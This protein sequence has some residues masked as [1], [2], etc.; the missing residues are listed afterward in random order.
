MEHAERVSIKD[1]LLNYSILGTLVIT[2]AC[3]VVILS[4][5][6]GMGALYLSI[7]AILGF[8]A[9]FFDI[10]AISK[11]NVNIAGVAMFQYPLGD[12][13]YMHGVF[14]VGYIVDLLLTVVLGYEAKLAPN[15]FAPVFK[16]FTF[17]ITITFASCFHVAINKAWLTARIDLFTEEKSGRV[18]A[19]DEE[20]ED[21]SIMMPLPIHKKYTLW[22]PAQQRFERFTII[23]IIIYI[24]LLMLNIIDI[25]SQL[26]VNV[27]I[28][29]LPGIGMEGPATGYI[30]L[31]QVIT[32]ALSTIFFVVVLRTLYI[33]IYDYNIEHLSS[34]LVKLEP[35]DIKRERII[36]FLEKIKD[37]RKA[38]EL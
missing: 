7:P 30:S 10:L 26:Q 1:I 3:C 29:Y 33:E 28:V 24:F 31:S 6:W 18:H 20:D 12:E 9:I 34:V 8:F 21:L 11:P 22:S 32:L 14:F 19:F 23:N 5:G 17:L 13:A 25:I 16:I 38:G 37:Y 4:Q 27:I 2:L 15:F 35:D 36:K